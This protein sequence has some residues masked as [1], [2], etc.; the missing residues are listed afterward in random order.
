MG[1]RVSAD[2]VARLLKAMNY[3]LQ[4][5]AK[6]NEGKQHADRDAQFHHLNA[7][8][9]AH[10]RAGEPVISGSSCRSWLLS[11]GGSSVSVAVAEPPGGSD[12]GRLRP[13]GT[14]DGRGRPCTARR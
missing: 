2:T 13:Y 3:S 5:P 6:E 10:Q 4:A 9:E 12:H 11:S 14:A 1:H 8:V 7:Q